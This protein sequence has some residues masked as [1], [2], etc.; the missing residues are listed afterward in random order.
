MSR[1]KHKRSDGRG[2]KIFLGVVVGLIL[3]AGI[4]YGIDYAL[5]KDKVPRGTAVG[6][7][8]IG[9]LAK[10]EASRTLQSELGGVETTPVTVTAG[11]LNSYFTPAEAGLGIDWDATVA[12][13]GEESANPFARLAG[14]FRT[15]EVDVVSEVDDTAL[16]PQLDRLT[17]E[18][19]LA[20]ADGAVHLAE[21]EVHVLDPVTGQD[22]NREELQEKISE[23]W[24]NPAGITVEA[25]P[26][27]PAIGA[28]TVEEIATGPAAA[29]VSGPLI[30]HGD[31]DTDALLEPA[32][33]GDFLHFPNDGDTIRTELDVEAAT[34]FLAAQLADTE[35]TAVNA[36]LNPDGSVTPHRDGRAIDWEVTMTDF[37]ARLLGAEPREWEAHYEDDPAGFTTDMA[38]N[39]D[40][41]QVMGEFTTSG[42]SDTSGQNIAVIVGD[43]SGAIVAP[44]EV[45]SLNAFTGPRGTAQGYVE[46]GTIENG[47]AGTAVGGGISQFAT[48]LYNAYYFAGLEDVTHTPHSYHISRYPAGR[49]AT[50]YEGAIDLA[51]RNQT[52]V[53]V[54]IEA[55]MGGGSLTVRIMGVDMYDVES[56]NG[57]RWAHTQ[58]KELEISGSD[59]IP[60][61][62]IP[63]FTTSETRVVRDKA[64]AEVSRTTET[65]V[66]DPQPIVRCT[67]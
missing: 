13:A 56:T 39:A 58:P 30:L 28:D 32:R 6:G 24:L 17:A 5:N 15:Q 47:R 33:V 31:D 55:T 16:H 65:T 19:S 14:L 62:G 20:P 27:E 35:A 18:L 22:I 53:P 49:E 41:T 44:G 37:P 57:G 54:R 40:F 36:R 3:I 1:V 10:T 11:E 29:A 67:G 26:R 46:G 63:G 61:S 4:A 21:G 8:D 66:Y 34:A 25:F 7:V 23:G 38:E 50:V 51:F 48:T 12:A 43:V 64:G 2:W 45:F 60:S 59:C 52:N 42:Y 9:G